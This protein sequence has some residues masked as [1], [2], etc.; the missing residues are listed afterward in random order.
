[1]VSLIGAG[2]ANKA[3][4]LLSARRE[5]DSRAFFTTLISLYSISALFSVG[6][7]LKYPVS[8][9]HDRVT[10][11]DFLL[12]SGFDDKKRTPLQGTGWHTWTIGTG[13]MEHPHKS[14]IMYLSVDDEL[15]TVLA[16]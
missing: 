3:H 5:S 11:M 7:L 10:R 13:V 16:N 8:R 6:I 2:C 9:S 1:M 15:A 14:L 12:T 4:S